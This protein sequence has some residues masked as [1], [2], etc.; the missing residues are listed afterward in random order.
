LVHRGCRL[1]ESTEYRKAR[2]FC[3]KNSKFD[4][5]LQEKVFD[6]SESDM[7][8]FIQVVVPEAS[9]ENIPECP[10]GLVLADNR[11]RGAFQ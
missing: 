10:Q 7:R 11:S 6:G 3:F 4:P 2:F 8:L 9:G 5:K 1:A